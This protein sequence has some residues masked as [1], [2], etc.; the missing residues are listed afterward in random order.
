M[1]AALGDVY[2]SAQFLFGKLGERLQLLEMRRG[3]Q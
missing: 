2:G 3:F 1:F